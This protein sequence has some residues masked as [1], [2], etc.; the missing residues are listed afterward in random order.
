LKVALGAI[1]TA[2]PVAFGAGLVAVTAGAGG[3][4]DVVKVQE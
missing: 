1:D 3:G 2:T 4:A